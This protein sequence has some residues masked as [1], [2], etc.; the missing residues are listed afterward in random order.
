MMENEEGSGGL[1]QMV[2]VCGPDPHAPV[3]FVRGLTRFPFPR[4]L[5]STLGVKMA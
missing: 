2:G 5:A 1:N 3:L 4:L